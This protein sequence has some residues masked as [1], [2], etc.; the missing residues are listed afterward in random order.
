MKVNLLELETFCKTYIFIQI[1]TI[2][3]YAK[4]VEKK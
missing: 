4:Q 1:I 3:K 2:I